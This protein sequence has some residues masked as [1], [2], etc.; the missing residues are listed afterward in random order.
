MS[1]GRRKPAQRDPAPDAGGLTVIVTHINADFDAV[2]SLIAARHLYPGAVCVIPG[3]TER[4]VRDFMVQ[5]TLYS[6]NLEGAPEIDLERVERLVVVDTRQAD[7]IGR[8]AALLGRDDVEVHIY[9]HHPDSDE[10]FSGRVTI[11]EPT[12]STVAVLVK[13]LKQRKIIVPPEQATVMAMGIYEDTGGLTFNSTTVD[14]YDAARYCLECGAELST[15]GD[16]MA[17]TMDT[18]QVLVLGDLLRSVRRLHFGSTPVA[19]AEAQVASGG[20][21]LALVVNRLAQIEHLPTIFALFRVE[22]R[23]TLIARSSLPKVDVGRICR[24]LG[25]GGHPTA[26]SASLP[27]KTL[28]EAHEL[29][30]AVLRSNFSKRPIA[31]Q[32]MTTSPRCIEYDATVEQA[33]RELVRWRINALCVVREGRFAGVITRQTVGGAMHHGQGDR[34]VSEFLQVEPQSVAP[35]ESFERIYELIVGRGNRLLP[36]VDR[37]RVLGVIARGDLLRALGERMDATRPLRAEPRAHR[38]LRN[39]MEQRLPR[40]AM[41]VLRKIG[42]VAHAAGYESYAVGGFVRDLI[43]GRS[44]LDVD[45]VVEGD[46]LDLVPQLTAKLGCRAAIHERYKTAK[47]IMPDGMRVDLASARWE[48]YA[49]PAAR[50]EVEIGSIKSDLFRRDFTINTLL[51]RLRPRGFGELLDHFDGRRDIKDSKLRVLHSLSFI[52][53]PTRILRA[54]RFLVRFDFRLGRQTEKLMNMAI[55]REFLSRVDGKRL[56]S[57]L[58]LICEEQEPLEVFEMMRELKIWRYFSPRILLDERQ[59]AHLARLREVLAWHALLYTGVRISLWRVWTLG[60]CNRMN[61]QLFGE[62]LERLKIAARDRERLRLCREQAG[63]AVQALARLRSPRPSTVD[64]ILGTLDREA[65]LFAMATTGRETT[66]QAISA[67]ISHYSQIGIELRGDD[68]LQLG[69]SSGPQI[70]EVLTRVRAAKLDERVKGR[71]EQLALAR[72]LIRR[73]H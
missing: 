24:E 73:R 43:I 21:D 71:S 30:R 20:Q 48:T 65:L 67:Y 46:V 44:N 41:A 32:I 61:E 6:L 49:E 18:E 58:R 51:I 42:R 33:L 55:S 47:L 9:D 64:R 14:D 69:L 63:D 37:G 54:V 36:V 31:E 59:H 50:P 26:A 38:S 62:F 27:D 12:G 70:G 35:K 13:L 29:L 40:K 57:E 19:L 52:E 66:R 3:G 10:D 45:V 2:G 7:R 34:P 8:M 60:L 5:S 56:L 11:V 1:A 17:R 15:V 16:L 4:T 22:G 53:D 72:R 39:Q 23:V 68:L 25:G 28:V